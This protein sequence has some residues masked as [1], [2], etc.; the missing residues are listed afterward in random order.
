LSQHDLATLVGSTRQ[1]VNACLRDLRDARLVVD[2]NRCFVLPD[3]QA[4]RASLDD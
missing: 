3:P 2:R 4:L 1:S